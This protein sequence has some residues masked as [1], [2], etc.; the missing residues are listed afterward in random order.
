MGESKYISETPISYRKDYGQFFEI[1][2]IPNDYH[3][4]INGK[5]VNGCNKDSLRDISAII[6]TSNK[7]FSFSFHEIEPP[8]E[9]IS[10]PNTTI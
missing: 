6:I 10:A 8:R 2:D 4:F 3:F 9:I 7:V 5:Y 1:K